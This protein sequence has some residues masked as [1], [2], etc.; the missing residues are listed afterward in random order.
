[1]TR[2]VNAIAFNWALEKH[3][4]ALEK[5]VLT[6]IAAYSDRQGFNGDGYDFLSEKA[7]VEFSQIRGIVEMLF[8]KGFLEKINVE[9]FVAAIVTMRGFSLPGAGMEHK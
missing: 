6:C 3:L 9:H 2:Y 7:A 5:L 1:M 8:K 4:S